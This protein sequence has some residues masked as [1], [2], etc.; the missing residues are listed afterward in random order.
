ML[1]L[2]HGWPI[3]SSTWSVFDIPPEVIFQELDRH[4]E[5]PGILHTTPSDWHV[6]LEVSSAFAVRLISEPTASEIKMSRDSSREALVSF[7]DGEARGK[8]FA[9]VVLVV[10]P[11]SVQT[12]KGW[13]KIYR[14]RDKE[15]ADKVA[16]DIELSFTQ[17]L[18]GNGR[19]RPERLRK[20]LSHIAEGIQSG[21]EDY[22]PLNGTITDYLAEIGCEYCFVDEEG[23]R[24]ESRDGGR[25]KAGHDKGGENGQ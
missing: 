12:G 8:T 3:V 7:L 17:G 2:D 9:I 19:Q 24:V 13:P 10:P 21:S 18:S 25:R 14:I 15:V 6:C 23:K 20:S 4:R 5:G 11:D 1:C 22:P 16:A